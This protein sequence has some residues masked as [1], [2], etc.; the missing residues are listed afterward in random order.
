MCHFSMHPGMVL[1]CDEAEDEGFTRSAFS[2]EVSLKSLVFDECTIFLVK[3]FMSII[4]F[5]YYVNYEKNNE[6]SEYYSWIF[7]YSN[8]EIK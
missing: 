7:F 2:L 4:E 5:Y 3:R 6:E 8:R 1:I